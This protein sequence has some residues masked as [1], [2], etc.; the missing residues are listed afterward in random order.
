VTPALR[1]GSLLAASATF[2]ACASSPTAGFDGDGRT[3]GAPRDAAVDR[4]RHDTGIVFGEDAAESGSDADTDPTT[5]AE[6]AADHS[7]VGCDFWPT[8]TGNN[9]WSV[10]DFAAVVANAGVLTADVT[11]TGPNGVNQ[12][13]TV[14]PGQLQKVYLPWVSALKGP[15]ADI[16]GGAVGVTSVLAPA[17]AYHLVSTAPV[18]VYQFNALEYTNT[19]GPPG[20]DWSSCPGLNASCTSTKPEGDCYSYTNDASLLLPT[21]ALTGT[22]RVTGHGGWG[23]AGIGAYVTVT[24]TA[25]D[26]TVKLAVSKTGVVTA[27]TGVPVTRAGDTYSFT[28]NRGDVV[29]L[30][31]DGSDASDLSGSLLTASSPV[32]VIT[33][34]PCF[35]L[36]EIDSCDHIEESNVPAET[37]GD[38]YVVAQPAGPNGVVVGQD[39]RIYGNFDDTTLTYPVGMPP[40]CPSKIDAG[41]VVDCGV[42]SQ[43]FEVKGTSSF[44]VAVFTQ[45]AAVVDSDDQAPKQMGDPDESTALPVA[46]YRSKYVFL[47]PT[48][49]EQNYVVIV[50]PSAAKVILDGKVVAAEAVP[51]GS[52]GW[53]V[54]RAELAEGQGGAHVMTASRPVGLTVMGYGSYTSYEYPGGLAL[55]R[56]SPPPPK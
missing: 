33:G 19:G 28:L 27:G 5:C 25:N 44:A 23:S 36:P 18:T 11:V 51:I 48:D 53:S 40:G 15:D 42:V 4:S 16:C 20:K 30:V 14:P 9:V 50:E 24:G 39:V 2:A 43:D 29:Q 17:S 31:S 34:M 52:T 7:Y 46:Q 3:G 37:L 32:Q 49:Y 26:T 22:Y 13:V 54:V 56:I 1:A 8:V 6:A 47:A 12:N 45:S 38:D 35:A 21:T 41:E 55:A 10:F